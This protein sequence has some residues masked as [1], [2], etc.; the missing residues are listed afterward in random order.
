MAF[1]ENFGSVGEKEKAMLETGL[2]CLFCFVAGG[3]LFFIG[4]RDKNWVVGIIASFLLSIS[5]LMSVMFGQ[6]MIWGTPKTPDML[7][8]G[9]LFRFA[10]QVE[11]GNE[12]TVVVLKT[13]EGKVLC[14]NNS[15]LL[16]TDTAYVKQG[17]AKGK[18]FVQLFMTNLDLERQNS[19]LLH[20][21]PV[22]TP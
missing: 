8:P 7:V 4:T 17:G 2:L 18:E 13:Q 19:L 10:G 3:A 15:I 22:S 16:P 1:F 20:Q 9:E 14:V 11:V 6:G 21:R 12:K 5:L